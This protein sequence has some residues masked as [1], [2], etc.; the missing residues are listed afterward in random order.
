MW[1]DVTIVLRD[2]T[3]NDVM[4]A[5]KEQMNKQVNHGASSSAKAGADYKFSMSIETLDGTQSTSLTDGV[6]DKW[7]LVGA[8]IPS[9]TFGDLNYATSDV[10][11]VSM[12]IRFDHA[13]L[14]TYATTST[15]ATL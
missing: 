11:Q 10:V 15:T 9:A 3:N 1:Q 2:D 14:Q 13:E 8:F 12:T 7:L 6:L 5:I 4:K